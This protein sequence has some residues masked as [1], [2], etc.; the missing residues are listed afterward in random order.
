MNVSEYNKTTHIHR[1]AAE[2]LMAANNKGQAIKRER[3][4]GRRKRSERERETRSGVTA[5]KQKRAA[6][7]SVRAKG[8][9]RE[10]VIVG[11]ICV[12]VTVFTPHHLK[13]TTTSAGHCF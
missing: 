2:C 5:A 11:D 13:D 7:G 10:R 6:I 4:R 12:Y 8:R 9:E 1:L 3:R